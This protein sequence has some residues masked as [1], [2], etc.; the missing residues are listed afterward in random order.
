MEVAVDHYSV[1]K[2]PSDEKSA[3]LTE[4]DISRAYKK[5]A[6]KLHP[7]KNPNDPNANAKFQ[8]LL[9]SYEILKDP[10]T[11][12]QFDDLLRFKRQQKADH[13]LLQKAEY[14][15][16]NQRKKQEERASAPPPSQTG[17]AAAQAEILGMVIKLLKQFAQVYNL[18]AA[19]EEKEK[20]E[21]IEK[22]YK[23]KEQRMRQQ[24]RAYYFQEQRRRQQKEA[25]P[26]DGTRTN[27]RKLQQALQTYKNVIFDGIPC[28]TDES[29]SRTCWET[30]KLLV[31]SLI[32]LAVIEEYLAI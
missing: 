3:S 30:I 12:K 16:Q 18:L 28:W 15:L 25:R 24:E 32:D 22:T 20:Q 29:D 31:V 8:K 10:E 23:F 1:L 13:D 21:E 26:E 5:T 19:E 17:E 9:S 27:K 4:D 2:L 6:L 11:R 14:D 7:D